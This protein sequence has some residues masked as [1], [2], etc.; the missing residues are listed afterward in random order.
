MLSG[1]A[2]GAEFGGNVRVAAARLIVHGELDTLT[3]PAN[4]PM[5]PDAVVLHNINPPA[6]RR[7]T[8]I[9]HGVARS[10]GGIFCMASAFP[11]SGVH[12]GLGTIISHSSANGDKQDEG[13]GGIS[14]VLCDVRSP[15]ALL[16][17]NK[18]PLEAVE[19][20]APGRGRDCGTEDTRFTGNVAPVGSGG[21]VLCDKC[22]GMDLFGAL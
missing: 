1:N 11:D 5:F 2:A 4:K 14:T 12:L 3:W 8:T 20:S 9:T 19:A 15:G 10:G 17:H 18:A 13:G 6:I 7:P 16:L 22:H 21:A